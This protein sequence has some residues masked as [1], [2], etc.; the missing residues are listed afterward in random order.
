MI[1]F[2]AF[3]FSESFGK[4]SFRRHCHRV[5]SF[6]WNGSL[7][8][9]SWKEQHCALWLKVCLVVKIPTSCKIAD[10]LD[11]LASPFSSLPLGKYLEFLIFWMFEETI[12][13]KVQV[14]FASGVCRILILLLDWSAKLWAWAL[15]HFHFPTEIT[16]QHGV[17]KSLR[18]PVQ[19]LSWKPHNHLKTSSLGRKL[20]TQIGS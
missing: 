2:A 5:S 16:S 15:E 11:G 4:K 1:G 18:G 6:H 19:V 20:S 9:G 3:F 8:V 14:I 10:T 17:I 13:L 12:S 7:L